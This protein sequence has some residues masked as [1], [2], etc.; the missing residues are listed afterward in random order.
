MKEGAIAPLE[1]FTGVRGMRPEVFAR[2]IN[3]WKGELE[4]GHAPDQ[5]IAPAQLDPAEEQ[6]L[7]DVGGEVLDV[8]RTLGQLE[9]VA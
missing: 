3:T 1:E 6:L 8:Y 5:Y 9:P 7:H 4:L 2:R